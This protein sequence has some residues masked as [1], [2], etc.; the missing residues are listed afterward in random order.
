M[1]KSSSVYPYVHYI[2]FGCVL[3]FLCG[4]ALIDTGYL[5]TMDATVK[6]EIK[7]VSGVKNALFGGEGIF[8]TLVTG[9]GRI[10]LQ[11]M[12]ISTFAGMIAS[13]TSS[14]R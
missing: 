8:N 3:L 4:I 1:W 2:I 5:A 11:T 7:R 13:M 9:P 6:M 12:P 10:V 14:R